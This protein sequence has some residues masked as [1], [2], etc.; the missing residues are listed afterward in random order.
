ME[1]LRPYED[2]LKWA[3][4]NE[5]TTEECKEHL[6]GR[7]SGLFPHIS[8]WDELQDAVKIYFEE[9]GYHLAFGVM[10]PYPTLCLWSKETV[11][12]VPVEIPEGTIEIEVREMDGV[13][14]GGWLDYLSFGRVGAGGWVTAKGTNY[15]KGKYDTAS[16]DFQISLLKHEGQHFFDLKN[17]P[18]MQSTDLE[19]RA[20][21]VELIYYKDM[22]C[23]FAFF[24]NM[25]NDDSKTYP[26]AYAERKIVQGLS[27]KIFGR[28]L[29]KCRDLWMAE[30]EKVPAATL[31]LLKEHSKILA[32]WDGE[33]SIT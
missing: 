3:L 20:K 25:S 30:K 13:I 26:H 7:L 1:F 5:T 15:F 32:G 18:K 29:E 27:A 23:F 24:A 12:T 11:R 9:R 33:S 4:K 2:Y 14:T 6:L 17:H 28:D 21:L 19:Y 22:G 10:Q 8:T 16:D 31:E